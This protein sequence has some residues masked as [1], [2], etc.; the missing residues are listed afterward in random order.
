MK[1]NKV[2][3]EFHH[4]WNGSI[5][6]L[7]AHNASECAAEQGKFWELHDV[8]LANQS[9]FTK[10]SLKALGQQ[11]QGMDQNQYAQCVDTEKYRSKVEQDS[12]QASSLGITS[13]PTILINNRMILGAQDYSV[14]KAAIEQALG[15]AGSQ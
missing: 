12:N 3:F 7:Y 2:R 10:A 13:T 8:I 14:F 15:E 1:T 6:S 11:V 9:A 4:R 5:P